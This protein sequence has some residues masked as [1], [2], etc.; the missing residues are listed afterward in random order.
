MKNHNGLL[1]A[2]AV[3]ASVSAVPA[4]SPRPRKNARRNGAPTRPGCRRGARPKRPTLNNARAGRSQPRPHPRPNRQRHR[5]RHRLHDR[6]RPPVRKPRRTAPPNGVPTRPACRR[7]ASPKRPMLNN[8]REARHRPR[9]RRGK[10]D[11]RRAGTCSTA[12]ANRH[13]VFAE[14]REGVHCRME[15]RQGGHASAW[16]DRE[17]LR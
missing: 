15:S 1:I 4:L 5:S 8:A 10:A 12:A 7:A 16:R 17:G 3:C 6:Q 14:N 2:A 9:R 11:R 13:F